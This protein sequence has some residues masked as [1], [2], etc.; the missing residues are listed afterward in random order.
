VADLAIN[1]GEAFVS[2]RWL[3]L[4]VEITDGRISA[5]SRDLISASR[6]IDAGGLKVIPGV[7]DSHTHFRAPA[8]PDKED[9]ASGTAA[10]AAGG[11]TTI[12][13]MPM[14][15]VATTTVARFEERRRLLEKDAVVDFAMIAGAGVE[16]LGELAG[17]ARA[18][19]LCFK[20]FLRP[21]YPGRE[22]NFGGLCVTNDREVFATASAVKETGLI[23]SVHAENHDIVEYLED[24]L[25]GTKSGVELFLDARPELVE[26]EPV[27]KVALL[28]EYLGV[29]VH[30]VH[31]TSVRAAD[32]IAH[33]RVRGVPISGEVCLPHLVLNTEDAIRLGGLGHLSPRVRDEDE[34]IELWHAVERGTLTSI[35]SDHASFSKDDV[36][37]GW[38][39]TG[40]PAAGGIAG[41]EHLLPLTA[42]EAVR[43]GLGLGVAVEALT[44][45]PAKHFGLWP[46]KGNLLPGADADITLLDDSSQTTIT[47]DA[48]RSKAKW[49]VFEG[50]EVGV[51]VTTT[52]SRGRV[53]FDGAQVVGPVGGGNFVPGAGG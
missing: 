5:L 21:S 37:K 9:F 1:G 13:E 29:P 26:V 4:N 17:M 10:A 32:I 8:H 33:A 51:R 48:M 35:C 27:S 16:G 41:T 39:S 2:G 40:K 25:A 18:G 20:S 49:T 12:A 7:I 31:V 24:Q 14:A 22:A 47:G 46:R 6:T 42:D 36:A 30:V 52:L 45:R 44:E 28:A 19:A 50:R 38:K 34:R 3:P 15:D 43:L 23:W 11:V 53:V